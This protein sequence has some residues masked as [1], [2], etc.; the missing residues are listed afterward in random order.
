MLFERF[1]D[2][3]FKRNTLITPNKIDAVEK[4]KLSFVEVFLDFRPLRRTENSITHAFQLT[5]TLEKL[6]EE[7]RENFVGK[8]F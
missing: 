6:S 8:I 1:T 4:M 3:E 2:V 7:Q 5:F